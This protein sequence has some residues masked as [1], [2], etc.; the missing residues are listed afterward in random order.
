IREQT[1]GRVTIYV[2]RGIKCEE[3]GKFSADKEY[4]CVI[5]KVHINNESVIIGGTYQSPSG[6]ELLFLDF[7]ERLLENDLYV[8][9]SCVVLTGDF[10]VN[11]QENNL[12]TRRLLNILSGGSRQIIQHPTRYTEQFRTLVDH[13][14]TNI[15]HLKEIARQYAMISDHKIIGTKFKLDDGENKEIV[16]SGDFS[17]GKIREIILHLFEQD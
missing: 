3:V 6:K 5:I 13:L 16:T 9:R 12:Y 8:S 11:L 10:N 1:H 15:A 17:E 2:K 14:Y 7:F 4:W